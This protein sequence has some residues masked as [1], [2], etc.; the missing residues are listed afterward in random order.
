MRLPRMPVVLLLLGDSCH[1]RP[2][3]EQVLVRHVQ[4]VR[5]GDCDLAFS[6]LASRVQAALRAEAEVQSDDERRRIAPRLPVQEL[7]CSRG[8]YDRVELRRTRTA[9]LTDAA[10]EVHLMEE[11]PA[12]HLVPGFWPTRTD[13]QPMPK[14]VVREGS[15]WRIED[16]V[17]LRHLQQQ[18]RARAEMASITEKVR[19]SRPGKGAA[20]PKP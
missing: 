10:A 8:P 1:P 20:P 12:G 6:L 15:A 17:L 13:L 5:D 2:A 18:A 9:W 4:A 3:H 16:E 14:K 11:V 7:Y 19:R